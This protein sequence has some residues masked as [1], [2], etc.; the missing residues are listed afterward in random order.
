MNGT[1]SNGINKLYAQLLAAKLNIANGADGSSINL[2]IS[3]SDD[4]LAT[5]NAN[6]W[7]TLT[8]AQ[9][10]QVLVWMNAM[11]IYNMG[12]NTEHSHLFFF[13]RENILLK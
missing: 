1:A 6:D 2:V 3:V 13:F 11:D 7:N 9:K 4:F 10:A 8:K 5:H 12:C